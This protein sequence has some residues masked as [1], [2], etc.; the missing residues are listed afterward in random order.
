VTPQRDI[1]RHFHIEGVG[2]STMLGKD[3]AEH[4]AVVRRD[5]DALDDDVVP[6]AGAVA[7]CVG[8]QTESSAATVV[9]P[10]AALPRS[11]IKCGPLSMQQTV[12]ADGRSQACAD[13]RIAA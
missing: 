7:D 10:N 8:E 2:W 1:Q 11:T 3:P 9:F 12:V 5:E 13:A 6:Q 4:V